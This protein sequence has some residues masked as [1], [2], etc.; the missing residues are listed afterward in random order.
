MT[1]SI[2][3][4]SRGTLRNEDI[5]A[6]LRE[7]LLSQG[8]AESET[9]AQELAAIADDEGRDTCHDSDVICE[10]FDAVQE[11]APE[12]CYVGMPEGDGS[13]LGVWF[14]SDAFEE[15]CRSGEILKISDS[16]EIEDMAKEDLASYNY[17]AVVSDHGNVTLHT[18][19]VTLG[20]EVFSII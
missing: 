8:Y 16:S 18:V 12:F 14:D 13:D 9:L 6:T 1:L 15:A 10:A 19:Q 17:F 5:A 7:M 4:Y 3:S 11:Y 20:D 2:G